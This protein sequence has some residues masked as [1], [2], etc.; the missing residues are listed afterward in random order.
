MCYFLGVLHCT[1]VF[2]M[3][4][5]FCMSLWNNPRLF[6]DRGYGIAGLFLLI[7]ELGNMDQSPEQLHTH[8]HSYSHAQHRNQ[9]GVQFSV[10]GAHSDA[11]RLSVLGTRH[12]VPVDIKSCH[13]TKK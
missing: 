10:H 13:Q 5:D 9:W 7:F 8:A 12:I 6:C 3:S 1:N 2:E 11:M 4:F